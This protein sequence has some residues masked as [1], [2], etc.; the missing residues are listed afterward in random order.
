V[1]LYVVCITTLCAILALVAAFNLECEQINIITAYLNAR[2][3]NDDTILLQLPL[4]CSGARNI[5][6]LQRGMYGLRQSAL[7]W[8][9][10]LKDSLYKLSF[11]PIKADPCVFVNKENAIIVVYVDDFILI[12]K[13]IA[14]IKE[15]KARLF[16]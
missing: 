4:G 13:D 3:T 10:D 14:S 6:R 1:Y 15:L 11:S 16:N 7:L 5:V 9:N 12:T 2:L 8:Y